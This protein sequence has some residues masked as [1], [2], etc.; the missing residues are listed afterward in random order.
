MLF[1]KSHSHVT[2]QFGHK[3]GEPLKEI[4]KKFHQAHN[5]AKTIHNIVD[6]VH[7]VKSM[8]EK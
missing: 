2:K 6:T 7:K 8:L 4:G 1:K 5:A 3:S